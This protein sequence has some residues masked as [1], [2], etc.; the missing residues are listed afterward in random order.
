MRHRPADAVVHLGGAGDQLVER[1][2]DEVAEL[3]LGDRPLARHG[4]ADRD[5]D[6]ARLGHRRVDRAGLAEALLEP[7]GGAERAALLADVLAHAE[8]AV[9]ELHL[10]VQRGVDRL[11]VGQLGHR[12]AQPVRREHAL[13]HLARVG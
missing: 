7:L 10:V 13:V 1:D 11:Q 3:H 8:H 6:D 9:V 4:G 5:A 12:Y 2:R